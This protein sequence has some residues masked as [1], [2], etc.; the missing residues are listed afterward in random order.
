MIVSRRCLA[1]RFEFLV[2]LASLCVVAVV[3]CSKPESEVTVCAKAPVPPGA[4]VAVRNVL[5]GLQ[6]K[7]LRAL[8]EFLPPS[9][10]ADAQK[11]LHDFGQRLDQNSWEPFVATFR[12]AHLVTRQIT[13]RLS[14]SDAGANESDRELIATLRDVEQFLDAICASELSDVARLRQLDAFRFLGGT[15]NQ[16][17]AMVTHGA[18]DESGLGADAFSQFGE[19][20][21]ELRESSGDSAVLSVQ[22]PG[23]EATQHKFVRVEERWIPQTL[24]E[25]WPAEFPNVRE[26]CL[27]WADELR[28]N[29][30]PW[31]ARLR[32]I[33]QLL[34]ELAATKSLA[35]TRQVWQTG[36]SRLAVTW[37]GMA[38]PEPPKTEEI[39]VG[40][41]PSPKPVRVKRPDTEVLLPDE[42][43]Q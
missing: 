22:W 16:L 5:A 23:Q 38:S 24:A 8:W 39:P 30:A 41:P 12:K 37:F 9:Y 29:P 26:Q 40:T 6:R 18:F 14:E 32:K 35:E 11:L 7:D 33:D 27:A 13:R 28:S 2:V 34:D 42:P 10:Q 31:H 19:V 4:D 15:G 17:I 1:V 36:A 25:A 20:N 43:Q 21:V 3:G